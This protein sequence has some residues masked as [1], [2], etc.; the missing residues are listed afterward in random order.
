MTFGTRLLTWLKGEPVGTDQF[1][2]R[3][4]R[5]RGQAPLVKGGGRP[6]REKRWV[7]YQGKVEATRVPPEWHAWLHHT[8]E[9]PPLHAGEHKYA[10][11][12][13]HKPNLTG[14]PE[15]YRPPGSVLMGGHRQAA[16]GDYEPWIPE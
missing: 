11:V 8:L 16:A 9:A 2:N 14:T 4:Y 3:Y 10:W 7:I 6:S 13:D 1:G 5:Q 15:A 12:K